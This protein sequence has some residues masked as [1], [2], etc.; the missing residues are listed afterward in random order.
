MRIILS[1][2]GG[3]MGKEVLDLAAKGVR[4]AEVVSGIDVMGYNGEIPTAISYESA[5][6]DGDV[7]IDFSHRA[8]TEKLLDFAVK[9]GLPLVLATT[10][11]TDEERELIKNAAESIPLF[12]ASNFSLGVALLIELAEKA[13]SVMTD[14]GIEIVETHHVRKAD[15][16]S[17]T[18]LSIAEGI[19][20]VRPELNINC[21][22]NGFCRKDK[23]ELGISSVRMGN[24]VGIHEVHICTDSQCITLKHEAFSRALFAEGALAAAEYLTGK[25]AGLYDMKAMIK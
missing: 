5:S 7:I 22:R 2:I 13:A 12:F 25:P 1:G 20:E 10:G 23:N 19:R 17:G 11:Q 21:G 18:A 9:N 4:N 3:H 16:P 15:A 24:I 6:A 8:N 14:A